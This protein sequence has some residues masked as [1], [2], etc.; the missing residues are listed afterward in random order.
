MATS[1]EVDAAE[2]EAHRAHSIPESCLVVLRDLAAGYTSKEIAGRHY[3]S[4]SCVAQRIW[5]ANQYLGTSTAC[6]A[7]YEATMRG[8]LKKVPR[9]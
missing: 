9:P 5:R 8:L 3:I 6:Q 4:R 7:V 2:I 1:L